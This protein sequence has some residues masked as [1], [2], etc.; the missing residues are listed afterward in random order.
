[1][2]VP[3]TSLIS[4]SDRPQ[5]TALAVIQVGET[6]TLPANVQ[7]TIDDPNDVQPSVRVLC[8]NCS[9]VLQYPHPVAEERHSG[10]CKCS[11][12]NSLSLVPGLSEQRRLGIC[13][14]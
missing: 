3:A 10:G 5:V 7:F 6:G 12:H 14:H 11:R 2:T 13:A 1:M 4:S 8:L 9:A